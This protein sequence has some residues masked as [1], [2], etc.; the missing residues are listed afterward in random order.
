MSKHLLKAS[1]IVLVLL[2]LAPAG[3]AL[4]HG[5]PVIAL[6][7][8]VAAAG[9]RITVT[10]SEMEPGEV[11]AISLEGLGTPIP[12]GQATATGAGEEGGFVEE[13]TIPEDT[14][15]GFY[16]VRAQGEGGKIATGELTVTPPTRQ[17]SAAPVMVREPT[18]EEHVLNR[19]KP[20]GEV[21]GVIAVAL[22]GVLGGFVLVRKSA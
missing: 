13:L 21:I 15:P 3:A 12:L 9:G 1:L 14:L 8:D 2:I 5:E 10:G 4:A 22:L 20:V 17:A 19:A 7:P 6:A 18:G 16:Q 11:F